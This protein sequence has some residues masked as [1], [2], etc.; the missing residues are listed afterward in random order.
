MSQESQAAE[1]AVSGDQEEQREGAQ[2]KALS[3]RYSPS[4]VSVTVPPYLPHCSQELN[5]QIAHLKDQLQEM[6][7][8]T[9]LEEKFIKKSTQVP[10]WELNSFVI[11]APLH[12]HYIIITAPLHHHYITAYTGRGGDS[13]A[14]SRW[15]CRWSERRQR[16]AGAATEGGAGGQ[17]EHPRIPAAP[18]HRERLL[19][20]LSPSLS[21]VPS[22]SLSPS[23]SSARVC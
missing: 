15:Q 18:L 4:P 11:A 21:L 17:P 20:S 23:L 6:K 10:N 19:P 5:E 22:L 1:D 9:G 3:T 14:S 7:A 16:A 2:C 8:K 12:H 13:A